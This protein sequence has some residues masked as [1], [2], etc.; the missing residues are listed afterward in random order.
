MNDKKNL[1]KIRQNLF[2]KYKGLFW[3]LKNLLKHIEPAKNFG[4]FI[5]YLILNKNI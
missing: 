3:K 1:I 5:K 4:T 2:I